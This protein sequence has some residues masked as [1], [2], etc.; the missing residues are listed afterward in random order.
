MPFLVRWPAWHQAGH[1][2]RRDRA[3]HRLR[4]DV[5]RG[6]GTAGLSRDARTQTAAGASVAAR[7][8]TGA[9]RC[10]T[11]ITTTR[12]TTTR[13]AHYGVRTR[14]HKL[15]YF[16]KKRIAEIHRHRLAARRD[17]RR[18]A[19]RLVSTV[20]AGAARRAD[21]AAVGRQSNRGHRGRV[22]QADGNA[23]AHRTG[24]GASG[25][26]PRRDAAARAQRHQDRR[27]LQRER[28]PQGHRRRTIGRL[29]RAHGHGLS[30]GHRPARQARGRHPARAR[31]RRRHRESHGDARDVPRAEAR[32]RPDERGSHLPG[33]RSGGSRA[34]GR[35][36]L[37]RNERLQTRPVRRHRSLVERGLVRRPAH[38]PIQVLLHLARRAHDG[39]PRRSESG[40]SGRQGDRGGLRHSAAARSPPASIPSSCR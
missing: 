5:H 18:G 26:H 17:A 16:W 8:Q 1:A 23:G 21:G 30:Q 33:L 31:H 34:A 3:E 10:I 32:R 36:A 25:V 35:Q 29:R 13:G 28:R 11:A 6:G 7:S 9:P 12:A 39:E 15:I 19:E 4:A 40:Q 2:K 37:A 14:T 24:A 27:H 20:A 38:H 22:D